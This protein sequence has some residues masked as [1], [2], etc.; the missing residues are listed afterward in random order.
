M[1]CSVK[2]IRFL[3]SSFVQ[4]SVLLIFTCISISIFSG[5]SNFSLFFFIFF[6]RHFSS[7]FCLF[8]LLVR[9][10][11]LEHP[12]DPYLMRRK[13]ELAI[14]LEASIEKEKAKK[15]AD[16]VLDDP[17]TASREMMALSDKDF[18]QWKHVFHSLDRG[19]QGSIQV[20]S[21]FA[22]V[23]EPVTEFGKDVRKSDILLILLF[24]YVYWILTCV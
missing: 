12:I 11:L 22:A 18:E 1:A 10:Q 9:L 14:L 15:S 19:E 13:I 6:L 17:L 4:S 16:D 3:T 8:F 2:V 21:V 7:F 5:I 20:E 23:E 24:I